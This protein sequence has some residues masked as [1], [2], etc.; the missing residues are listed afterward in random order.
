M[1]KLLVTL[2][3]GAGFVTTASAL[4]PLICST[5]PTNQCCVDEVNIWNTIVQARG[6]AIITTDKYVLAFVSTTLSNDATDGSWCVD[7]GVYVVN[8]RATTHLPFTWKPGAWATTIKSD[9]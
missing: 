9:L 7:D 1:K 6:H 5:N 4:T 3:L 2:L 8:D